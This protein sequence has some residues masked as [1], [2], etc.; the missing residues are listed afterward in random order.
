MGLVST[1]LSAKGVSY[2]ALFGLILYSVHIAF[3]LYIGKTCQIPVSDTLLASNANI[4]NHA[5]ASAL[6]VAKGWEH[7]V[8]PAILVGTFGNAVGTFLGLWFGYNILQ[9]VR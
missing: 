2:L 4:G 1:A 9:F 7:K 3:I 8:L 6:A 5:T